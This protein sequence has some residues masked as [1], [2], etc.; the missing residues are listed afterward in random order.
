MP[1]NIF[2]S[3]SC[4][5]ENIKDPLSFGSYERITSDDCPL[6]SGPEQRQETQMGDPS[7]FSRTFAGCV[8]LRLLLGNPEVTF[9]LH[10]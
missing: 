10:D 2:Q 3:S 4:N 7:A 1:P 5:K 8:G 9:P 6:L